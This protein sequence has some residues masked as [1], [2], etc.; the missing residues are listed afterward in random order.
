MNPYWIAGLVTIAV[1]FGL[2]L[3]W[4]HRQ[5]RDEEINRAFIRDIALNHLPH[6]YSAMRQIAEHDGIT[7][8]DP[9]PI[10]FVDV[11]GFERPLRR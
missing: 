10:R 4:L 11:Y 9:P 8:E 6:L 3:R 7:L 2:F 1:Q 5:L